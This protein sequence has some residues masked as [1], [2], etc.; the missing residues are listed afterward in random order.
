MELS[1]LKSKWIEMRNNNKP[2][3]I[4]FLYEYAIHKGMKVTP[5]ILNVVARFYD[6]KLITERLDQE[7]ELNIL[8]DK[9]DNFIK[10]VE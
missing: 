9:N 5:E 8:Y 2:L 6:P 4:P 1:E 7:F 10:R 3:D